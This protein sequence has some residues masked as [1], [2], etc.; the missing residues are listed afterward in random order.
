MEPIILSTGRSQGPQSEGLVEAQAALQGS[1]LSH[2]S[3]L[4]RTEVTANTQSSAGPGKQEIKSREN[5]FF[6]VMRSGLKMVRGPG[7]AHLWGPLLFQASWSLSIER[8]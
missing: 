5:S 2:A 3:L 4:L 1:F 6:T 8:E 7:S